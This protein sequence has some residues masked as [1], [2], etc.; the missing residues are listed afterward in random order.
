MDDFRPAFVRNPVTNAERGIT[1]P[2]PF[3]DISST[4]LPRTIKSLYQWCKFYFWTNP[5]INAICSKLAE[6]P[7]TDIIL[8][9]RDP[10]VKKR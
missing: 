9:S 1:Y 2:S 7:I 3:F 6:Y 10:N 4:Y 8:E 5:L